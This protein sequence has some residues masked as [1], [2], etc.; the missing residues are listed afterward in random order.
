MNRNSNGILVADN[1]PRAKK[2]QK[3]VSKVMRI[4]SEHKPVVEL[5]RP[6]IDE[7]SYAAMYILTPSEKE[8]AHYLKRKFTVVEQP[9]TEAAEDEWLEFPDYLDVADL[10]ANYEE[11]AAFTIAGEL[12]RYIGRCQMDDN[13]VYR[14]GNGVESI[15]IFVLYGRVATLMRYNDAKYALG[16]ASCVL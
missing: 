5:M 6:G 13:V 1:L 7:T 12:Y 10:H 3:V 8:V 14:Y 2:F 4:P 9:K 16:D 15:L 11:T